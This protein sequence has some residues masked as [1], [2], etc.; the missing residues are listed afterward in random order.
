ML[1]LP[2]KLTPLIVLAVANFVA[3]AAFPDVELE[4]ETIPASV[5]DMTLVY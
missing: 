5:P 4:T 2:S 3:V 1:A